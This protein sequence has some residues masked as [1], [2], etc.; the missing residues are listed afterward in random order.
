MFGTLSSVVQRGI[1]PVKL[2]IELH[3]G[4]NLTE[5]STLIITRNRPVKV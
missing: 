1:Q 2:T 3:S 5:G 4:K